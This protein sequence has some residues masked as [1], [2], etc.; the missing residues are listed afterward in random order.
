MNPNCRDAMRNVASSCTIEVRDQVDQGR[1][2]SSRS[3]PAH[4]LPV[5]LLPRRASAL[6]ATVVI[7]PS[8]KERPRGHDEL[9]PTLA[10]ASKLRALL[11]QRARESENRK[12]AALGLRPTSPD[13]HAPK[14][15]VV[16]IE[17]LSQS[18]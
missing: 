17:L 10:P 4:V 13:R 8:D 5:R 6:R 18:N 1:L 7:V 12:P 11:L 3:G 14:R 2:M 16:P 9:R 15:S